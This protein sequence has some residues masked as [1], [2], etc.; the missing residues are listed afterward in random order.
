MISKGGGGQGKGVRESCGRHAT[1]ISD[2]GG[3]QVGIAFLLQLALAE[4]IGDP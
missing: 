2:R 1:A 3:G 4:T